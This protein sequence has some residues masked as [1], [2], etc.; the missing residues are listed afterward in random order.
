MWRKDIGIPKNTSFC[1]SFPSKLITPTGSIL[2]AVLAV[3]GCT[4]SASRQELLQQAELCH[5][6]SDSASEERLLLQILEADLKSKSVDSQT[7]ELLSKLQSIAATRGAERQC[8]A[9][10]E[11]ALS[12]LESSKSNAIEQSEVEIRSKL[13]QL[14]LSTRELDKAQNVCSDGIKRVVAAEGKESPKLIDLLSYYIGARCGQG[15]CVS[16]LPTV[17][18]LL[19]LRRK[20]LGEGAPDTLMTWQLLAE[21]YSKCGKLELAEK[22]LKN[23]LSHCDHRLLSSAY[24]MVHL[25]RILQSEGKTGEAMAVLNESLAIQEN[26]QAKTSPVYQETKSLIGRCRQSSK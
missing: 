21:E 18:R 7:V 20:Y 8:A 5:Q 9:N 6:R 22:Q 1:R 25:G 10:Y 2:L 3:S 11:R 23:G 14:F 13:A 24:L 15:Q 12:V 26:N 17:E 19:A 16:A 4:H